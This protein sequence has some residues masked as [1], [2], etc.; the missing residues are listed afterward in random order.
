MLP[1]MEAALRRNEVNK[2]RTSW[3]AAASTGQEAYSIGITITNTAD[4]TRGFARSSSK[5][6]RQTFHLPRWRSPRT[7]SMIR[8]R[9]AGHS[10]ELKSRYFTQDG[11]VWKL[12][13]AAASMAEFRRFNLMDSIYPAGTI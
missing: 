13:P 3:S 1:E 10:D 6:S 7:P 8:L 9:L 4:C 5:S 11:R 12:A 2:V